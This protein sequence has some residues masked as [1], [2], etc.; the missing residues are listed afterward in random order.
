MLPHR[1]AVL[2][3]TLAVTGCHHTPSTPETQPVDRREYAI[4]PA[5]GCADAS[6]RSRPP[7]RATDTLTLAGARD[8]NQL[9]AWRSL[10][11]PGG[12]ADGPWPANGPAR[13]STIWLRDP[14]SKRAALAALDTLAPPDPQSASMTRRDSVIAVAARWDSAELYDWLAYMATA[15]RSTPGPGF[16]SYGIDARRGRIVVGIERLES[17]PRLTAWLQGLGI[18]C[19]LFTAWQTGPFSLT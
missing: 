3:V 17:L 4:Q 14:S 11:V 15:P 7:V 12:W 18:P 10:R 1:A 13:P 19:D 2:A 6:P 9:R 16:N 8:E 5:G